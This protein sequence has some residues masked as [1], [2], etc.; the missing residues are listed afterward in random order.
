MNSNNKYFLKNFIYIRQ[1]TIYLQLLIC[2]GL[3]KF[4]YDS[5]HLLSMSLSWAKNLSF[6]VVVWLGVVLWCFWFVFGFRLLSFG[7]FIT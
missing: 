3:E 4:L 5:R 7:M 1:K 6:V 2:F